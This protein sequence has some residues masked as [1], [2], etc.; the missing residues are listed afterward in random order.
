MRVL[1]QEEGNGFLGISLNK[2]L[3]V[4]ILHVDLISWSVAEYKRYIKIF[5]FYLNVLKES[6]IKEVYSLCD[7]DKE[8][9]FNKLFGFE[10]TGL[11]ATDDSGVNSVIL[12]LEL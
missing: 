12:R 4:F 6:G 5:S 1:Y 7:S 9:K 10:D 11:G 3:D 2:E 8:V